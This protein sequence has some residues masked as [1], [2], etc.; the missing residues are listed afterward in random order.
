M[1]HNV[2]SKK[3]LVDLVVRVSSRTFGNELI[4]GLPAFLLTTNEFPY[5]NYSEQHF[6]ALSSFSTFAISE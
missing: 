5:S 6:L 4:D 3:K 2:L 1:I